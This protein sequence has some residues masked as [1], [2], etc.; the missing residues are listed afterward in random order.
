MGLVLAAAS[1]FANSCASETK[2]KTTDVTELKPAMDL[3]IFPNE[4]SIDVSWL[5]NN[6][7]DDFS[8]Y[9]IYV[10]TENPST[11]KSNFKLSDDP[12][13]PQAFSPIVLDDA[14]RAI[15]GKYFNWDKATSK[16]IAPT[17]EKTVNALVRCNVTTQDSYGECKA[18]TD[19]DDKHEEYRANG[20]L[21]YRITGLTKG[22]KYVVVVSATKDSGKKIISPTSRPMYVSTRAIQ[23]LSGLALQK[24]TVSANTYTGVD[25]ETMTAVNITTNNTGGRYC[26]PTASETTGAKADFYFDLVRGTDPSIVGANGTRIAELGPVEAGGKIFSEDLLSNPARING[27]GILPAVS[28]DIAASTPGT[29]DQITDIGVKQGYSRCGQSVLLLPFHLYAIAFPSGGSWKYALLETGIYTD[30]PKTFKIVVAN[31]AGERKL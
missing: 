5:A 3:Q 16:N 4:T 11:I 23:S 9:N 8:G 13:D 29:I 12:Y 19:A 15:F 14:E 2:P 18:I 17:D 27:N 30:D 6:N 22:T 31:E 21:T 26:L 28:Q 25:I 20:R 24:D 10:T 1:I 7:E